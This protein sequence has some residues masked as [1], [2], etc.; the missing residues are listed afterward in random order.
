M[1]IE[2]QTKNAV[3]NSQIGLR[4]VALLERKRDIDFRN[5][6]T[7]NMETYDRWLID[8]V[9]LMLRLELMRNQTYDSPLQE[10]P[11]TDQGH[12]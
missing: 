1:T 7:N 4:V 9:E 5:V 3:I 6:N 2:A 10:K 11:D 12:A 8:A